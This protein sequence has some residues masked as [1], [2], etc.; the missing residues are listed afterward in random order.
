MRV[1]AHA[2]D[3]A[4]FA[5]Y[6][7]VVRRPTSVGRTALDEVLGCAHPDGELRASMSRFEPTLLPKLIPRMERHPHA[8]QLFVPVSGYRYLAATALGADAPDLA[9]LDAFV[10]PGDVGIGY[11]I[12][13][14][15]V[16]MMVLADPGV[17]LVLMHWVSPELDEEWY[18]L[19]EP[20]TL[21]GADTPDVHTNSNC[22][23]QF[24]TGFTG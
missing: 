12:G 7:T 8:V 2:L 24:P 11:G 4:R 5:R 14:W 22:S 16:P 6:G 3:E 1:I 17:F 18:T 13:V 10:V 21:A 9:T 19:P 20:I 23:G 15:H